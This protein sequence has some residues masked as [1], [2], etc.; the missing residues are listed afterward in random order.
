MIFTQAPPVSLNDVALIP[1][2]HA[3][4]L[5]LFGASYFLYRRQNYIPAFLL[6]LTPL[7]TIIWLVSRLI[8]YA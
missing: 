2:L 3:I 7:I 6:V 8:Q 5:L 1:I 4:P